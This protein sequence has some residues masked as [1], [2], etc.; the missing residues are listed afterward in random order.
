MFDWW[1][2]YEIEYYDLEGVRHVCTISKY[3]T[4]AA[5][6]LIEG[7][8]TLNLGSIDDLN[9]VIRGVGITLNLEA[10]SERTLSDLYSE[11][12]NYWKVLY[13]RDG[14]KLFDGFI[15]NEGIYE[16]FVNDKWIMSIDCVDG[17]GNLENLSYVNTN[18]VPFSGNQKLIEIIS[19]CL[20][21]TGIS[22]D[23]YTNID[24]YY[25]GL[26]TSLDVLNNV[27][28]NADRFI[29]DDG[30]TI[31]SC[32]DVLNDVLAPFNA[33]VTTASGDPSYTNVWYIY[34]L[35]QLFNDDTPTFFKYYSDGTSYGSPTT[36]DF[37]SV[38]GSQIDGYYPHHVNSNQSIRNIKSL[39]AYRIN[40]KY[41]VVKSLLSNI[42][43]ENVSGS[44]ED[45]YINSFTN[46]TFNP[47]NLGVDILTITNG[48]GVKNMTSDVIGLSAGD[49]ISYTYKYKVIENDKAGAF[50]DSGQINYK[51][52]LT[53]G[54][55]TYYWN[56][57]DWASFDVMLTENIGVLGS[58]ST[59]SNNLT[60]LPISGDVTFE[61]HTSTKDVTAT[62]SSKVH[63]QEVSITAQQTGNA[64]NLK[65]EFHTVQR[66]DAPSTKIKDVVTVNN[67]DNPS[68]I[69]YGTIYKTDSTTPTE[70]WF[71]KGK[72]E[73]L[74]LLQ[75]MGEE[76]LRLFASTS[77]EFSGDFYGYLPHYSI[78]SINGIS[79]LFVFKEYSY[80]SATNITS[81]K[82]TQIYGAE[83]TDI[84]YELTYDYG[85]VVKPTIKG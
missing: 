66:E 32:A 35:N 51:I 33:V 45:W 11:Q 22:K 2:I 7:S 71:R 9:G 25:T 50:P 72:T 79:A 83:L 67:G 34:K 57:T 65:G 40:Y 54:V 39:A 69:Y 36:I 61:I 70:T 53:N 42:F 75:I 23:I 62:S 18:G 21:R 59:I 1:N 46:L 27:Y 55:S 31:M 60:A 63:I 77:K 84:N 81:M 82:L 6:T 64:A 29:K 56:I 20:I 68:D 15:S 76:T 41:G 85:N 47:S 26:S 30:E 43:L 3:T 73:S 17:L 38:L 19:N 13:F 5:P 12:E 78:V 74:S 80:D 44:I 4:D 10:S 16:D 14:N 24:T 52:K 48:L 49:L 58:V 37:S 28:Y 8:V